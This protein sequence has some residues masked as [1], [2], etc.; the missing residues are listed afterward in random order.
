[1]VEERGLQVIVSHD[2]DN[3]VWF[4]TESDVPGLNA[5]AESFDAL[6]AIVTELAPE[7]I[8]SNLE[9]QPEDAAGIPLRVLHTVHLRRAKAA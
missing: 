2:S 6:V 7:L 3:G 4:V 9:A 8:E 5:E 1:M